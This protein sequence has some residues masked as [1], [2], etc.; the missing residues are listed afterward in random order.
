MYSMTGFAS[1]SIAVAGSELKC[2]LRAVNHRHL[3]LALRLPDEFRELEPEFRD[4]LREQLRRGKVECNLRYNLAPT[5]NLGLDPQALD[6]AVQMALILTDRVPGL[7]PGT[8]PDWLSLPGLVL[9]R[10][11]AFDALKPAARTLFAQTLNEFMQMRRREGLQLSGH[12]AARLAD[13][14]CHVAAAS[15]LLPELRTS[16]RQRLR[17]RIAEIGE[18]EPQRFEQELVLLLQRADV[19]EE[20]SRLGVHLSETRLALS[21][22]GPHGRRLDFLTQELLREANTLGSKAIDARLS[23]IAL[24]IKLLIEQIREQAQN[25]E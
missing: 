13:I 7:S 11:P 9:R 1:A 19:D 21:H 22:D 15:S 6:A 25:V 12:I 23:S 16:A 24:E 10:G 3:D 14:E 17:L 8:V 5:E 4:A 20:L 2:E 18:L